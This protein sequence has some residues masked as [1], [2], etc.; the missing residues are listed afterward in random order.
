[1]NND[2]AVLRSANTFSFNNNVRAASIAG[3]NY[4]LADNQAVWAAGW[5]TTSVSLL[6]INLNSCSTKSHYVVVCLI[7]D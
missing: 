7:G 1:M 5:G 6:K 4:N 2:I 3:A